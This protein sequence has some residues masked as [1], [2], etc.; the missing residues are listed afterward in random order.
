MNLLTLLLLAAVFAVI[1]SLGFGIAAMGRHGEV[2]HHTSHEWMVMRVGFQ[3]LAV[4]IMLLM[5]LL[6]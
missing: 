1:G 6:A 5:L 2:L 3:A 4:G